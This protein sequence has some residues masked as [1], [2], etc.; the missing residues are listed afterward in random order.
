V[1]LFTNIL[2]RLEN[3]ADLPLRQLN[4]ARYT[5]SVIKPSLID[6]SS[7]ILSACDY[8]LA[9]NLDHGA[10]VQLQELLYWSFQHS[11]VF[12]MGIC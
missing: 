8:D 1:I 9:N 4:L 5:L 6:S 11:K 2:L 12:R 7:V 10:Y 3:N